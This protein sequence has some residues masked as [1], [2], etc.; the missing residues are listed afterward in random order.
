MRGSGASSLA[1]LIL[2]PVQPLL[3]NL[4]VSFSG[5]FFLVV[6]G[7][8]GTTCKQ[9]LVHAYRVLTIV[10]RYIS[11]PSIRATCSELL[12]HSSPANTWIVLGTYLL[13][14]CGLIA[15]RW[16]RTVFM[17]AS[18]VLSPTNLSFNLELSSSL[19]ARTCHTMFPLSC[20]LHP[21]CRSEHP[22]MSSASSTTSATV[23]V[24][25]SRYQQTAKL[26]A[27]SHPSE[28]LDVCASTA[29]AGTARSPKR[30]CANSGCHTSKLT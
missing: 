6:C 26:P 12:S 21:H 18:L 13:Q 17:C 19:T 10:R 28:T 8:T 9:P 22:V 14:A 24:Y 4:A 5:V 3:V 15:S 11:L 30:N 23:D 20:P 27:S 25:S 2:T 16:S 29:D 7:I 1:T